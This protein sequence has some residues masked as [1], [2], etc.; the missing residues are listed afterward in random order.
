MDITA[1][2]LCGGKSSRMGREKTFEQINGL[3]IIE[4]IL[5]VVRN[6]FQNIVINSNN[7]HLFKSYNL[8][9]IEDII[10]N[11]KSIGGIYSVL[12][13]IDTKYAFVVACDMPFLLEGAFRLMLKKIEENDYDIVFPKIQGQFQPFFAIYSKNCIPAI[14]ELIYQGKFKSSLLVDK[15]NVKIVDQGEFKNISDIDKLF[16][17]INT[18][19]DFENALKGRFKKTKI[20]GI[21][22]KNSNSGKTT[23]IRKLI[24][25]FKDEKFRVAVIKNTFHKIEIDKEGKDSYHFFQDGADAVVI[26]SNDEIVIRKRKD[27]EHKFPIKYIRDN[28]L[29]D[30]DVIILE[31][32]KTGNIPKIELIKNDQREFIFTNDSAV[33]AIVSDKYIDTPLPV[34]KFDEDQKIFEFIKNA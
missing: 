2:I 29:S 25:R 27:E 13:K 12:K 20:F 24:K 3:P 26:T 23:L 18:E 7:P 28:Y 8:P 30:V 15:V 16:F 10:P 21:V 6:I 11:K 1:V 22:A 5:N 19:H 34:F 9:V 14:E 33:S 32:H 17:N 4:H 31:G